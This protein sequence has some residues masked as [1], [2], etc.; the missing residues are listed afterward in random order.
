MKLQF[1]KDVDTPT[2][3]SFL[4]FILKQKHQQLIR[5]LPELPLDDRLGKLNGF[6][7]DSMA[8]FF[9]QLGFGLD[10]NLNAMANAPTMIQGLLD[11]M[12]LNKKVETR[13]KPTV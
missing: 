9:K 1:S 13:T 3:P 7:F 4:K 6:V 11:M 12:M 5:P 10:V 2:Y 8:L